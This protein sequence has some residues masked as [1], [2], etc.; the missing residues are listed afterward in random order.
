MV[1]FDLNTCIGEDIICSKFH[2]R[3]KNGKLYKFVGCNNCGYAYI[4]K[5]RL[6]NKD[7]DYRFIELIPIEYELLKNKPE[8]ICLVRKE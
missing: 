2:Q 1:C 3:Y 6:K 8:I 7:N 4:C 5:K